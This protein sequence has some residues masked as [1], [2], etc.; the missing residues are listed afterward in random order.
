MDWRVPLAFGGVRSRP[1]FRECTMS[2][3]SRE[4]VDNRQ[5]IL[6]AA[7][8]LFAAQ[9]FAAT[10][11]RE[12]VQRADV[13]APVLYYYFGSKDDLLTTLVSERFEQYFQRVAIASSG[14]HTVGQLLQQW[15][16]ILLDETIKRPTTL[17]LILGAMWGPP[18]PHLRAVVFGFHN[19]MVET[20][21]QS[22]QLIDP[23]ITELRASFSLIA[24]NGLMNSFMFPLLQTCIEVN[25]A[26][27]VE[28]VVPRVKTILYDTSP[29]P[30]A[31]INALESYVTQVISD[32]SETTKPET[33]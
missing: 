22:L 23:S 10:S 31:T 7:E 8:E 12:I 11:V 18:V 17:R 32:A 13:T 2:T 5:R 19:K 21:T 4:P 9:G 14:A 20:Y 16:E 33:P 29:I 15:C 24:L 27:L 6:V 3:S 25:T 30:T 26:E 28:T 1:L